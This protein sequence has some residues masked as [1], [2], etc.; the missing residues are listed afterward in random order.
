VSEASVRRGRDRWT[1]LRH[2]S[3]TPA[4]CMLVTSVCDCAVLCRYALTECACDACAHC[5]GGLRCICRS[6]LQTRAGR[7]V[8]R[9]SRRGREYE[10]GAGGAA[11]EQAR[12]CSRT[13][14][15]R[16]QLHTWYACKRVHE[17]CR[18]GGAVRCEMPVAFARRVRKK[19]SSPRANCRLVPA[20]ATFGDP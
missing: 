11:T 3:R 4:A 10:V 18:P 7:T 16:C 20:P 6:R 2:Q 9:A 13:V 5:R 17:C 14:S 12:W 19:L 8:Q 1:C 15:N